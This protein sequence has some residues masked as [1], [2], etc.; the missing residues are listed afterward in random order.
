MSAET[1]A[2]LAQAIE[3]HVRD[4]ADGAVT[5]G[6]ELIAAHVT[7]DGLASEGDNACHYL[8]EHPDG[9][10]IHVARGLADILPDFF[11]VEDD[12]LASDE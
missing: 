2:A 1:K 9:Q 7:P 11:E 10:F 4:E 12:G 8:E 6:W 5:V 3:A